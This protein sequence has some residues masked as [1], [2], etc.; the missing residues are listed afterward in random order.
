MSTCL[1]AVVRPERGQRGVR[2]IVMTV[3]TV[4]NLSAWYVTRA[5]GI[6][7]EVRAVDDVSLTVARNEIYGLAGE[8][9]CGKSTLIKTIAAAMRP[10]LRVI[11]GSV[12]F[13]FAG[14]DIDMHAATP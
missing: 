14:R 4:S 8:S 7:R 2:S 11:G 13:Q 6:D 5:F 12:T 3:L 1:L 9:S 10:P